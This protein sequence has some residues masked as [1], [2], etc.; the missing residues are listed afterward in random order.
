MMKKMRFVLIIAEQGTLC[1]I[2]VLRWLKKK[3]K[4]IEIHVV[5]FLEG[6]RFTG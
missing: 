3:R 6:G 4:N 2:I 5:S 1:I